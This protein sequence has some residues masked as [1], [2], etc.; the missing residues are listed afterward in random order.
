M[1][2]ITKKRT[3]QATV[4]LISNMFQK[5]T[6]MNEKACAKLSDLLVRTVEE[7]LENYKWKRTGL[8]IDG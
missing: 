6:G 4:D 2:K 5:Q 3:R 7:S 8:P 1:P